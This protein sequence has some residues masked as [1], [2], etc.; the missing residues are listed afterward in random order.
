MVLE[1]YE[2]NGRLVAKVKWDR[3]E[4]FQVVGIID[5]DVEPGA[6]SA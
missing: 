1:S 5:L 3:F 2:L 6:C 4:D